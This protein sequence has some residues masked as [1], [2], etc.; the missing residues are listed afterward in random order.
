MN[1]FDKYTIGKDIYNFIKMTKSL[2]V[3]ELISNYQRYR[4]IY[5]IIAVSKSEKGTDNLSKINM[6]S[7][8]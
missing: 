2:F 5:H 6:I 7:N 8:G 1:F 4:N 3:E